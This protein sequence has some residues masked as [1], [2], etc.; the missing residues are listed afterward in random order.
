[1]T[2]ELIVVDRS[3]SP[4]S[5]AL[6]CLAH[7]S[8]A[9]YKK[10]LKC[11]ELSSSAATALNCGLPLL[12]IENQERIEDVRAIIDNVS[13]FDNILI[14]SDTATEWITT[15]I[16]N[17]FDFSSKPEVVKQLNEE[18]LHRTFV[19]HKSHVTA[20]DFLTFGALYKWMQKADSAQLQLLIPIIRWYSF[21]QQLPGVSDVVSTVDLVAR[22][23]EGR[24]PKNN[25][26]ESGGSPTSKGTP[27][28]EK[29]N[30]EP[31]VKPAEPI[32]P[33]NDATR[34]ELKVGLITKV[35]AHPD[36]DSLYCE[37]IDVGESEVRKIASGLRN[38]VSLEQMEN[39]TVIIL[40]N[41]KIK[42]LRGYPSHG[43]V[44]CASNADHT[45]VEPLRPPPGS[46]PGDI[47]KFEGLSGD[48]DQ[49]L[50]TKKN[51]EPLPVILP[52]LIVD[53]AGVSFWKQH[54][55]IHA[56]LGGECIADTIRNGTIS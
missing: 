18:L 31:A 12:V 53:S 5:L 55:M 4:K 8:G 21:M 19:G 15:C 7:G 41:M 26:A 17:D 29:K 37:E 27:K 2:S 34:M 50:S 3:Q 39:R 46:K 22:Y 48:P 13:H 54:K 1:M 45:I 38:F 49:V 47:I 40:A 16:E 52:N 35:W 51:H 56:T 11:T 6:L 10:A 43:M 9:V 23:E 32:R 44:M 20:S 28:K 33:L 36:A 14:S 30:V 42:N 24:K 25:K